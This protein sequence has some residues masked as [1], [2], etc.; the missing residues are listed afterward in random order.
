MRKWLASLAVLGVCSTSLTAQTIPVPPIGGLGQSQQVFFDDGTYEVGWK[1]SWPAA[2]TDGYAVDFDDIC[3]NMTVNGVS[4][5]TFTSS[6]TSGGPVGFGYIGLFP[7]NLGVSSLGY[8]PDLS[9]PLGM[10]SGTITGSPAPGTFTPTTVGYDLPDTLV[11]TTGGMHAVFNFLTGDSVSWLTAD[12]TGADEG[13]STF[14]FTGYTTPAILESWDYPIRAIGSVAAA[15]GSA[16][17]TVNNGTGNVPVGQTDI[18]NATLWSTC[19]TQP[20]IYLQG[21]FLPTFL[22]VPSFVLLTG[23]EN[24]SPVTNAFMGSLSAPLSDP[25]V[26]PC[27]P[28]GA[29]FGVGAFYLDNC[30]LKK[31]G[32]PKLR[33]S[34]TVTVTVTPNFAACNPCLCF[35]QLDDGS[36]DFFIWKVQNP[37]GSLDFFN[38]NHGPFNDLAGVDCGTGLTGMQIASWDFCGTGPSW[39][40]VGLYAANTGVDP[41]GG[42]PD[43]GTPVALS[44]SLSMAPGAADVG[45][46]ATPY[47]FASTVFASTNAVLLAGGDLN[48][49]AK[50][51]TGDTC[52]WHGSDSDGIDDD[53][54]TVGAGCTLI[55]SST[56]F[57]AVAGYSVPSI[58]FTGMN[59]MQKIDWF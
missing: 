46:P 48:T 2:P 43:L 29:V 39:A 38:V 12:A 53:S 59:W 23:Y 1:V 18:I 20:T 56:T 31:N 13:H 14:T 10:T 25:S 44:T 4:I 16:Y 41:S 7:D 17:I 11:P 5:A 28:A 32:K 42:T 8:T 15:P 21:V 58:P 26:G 24:F 49:A 9:L 52:V 45:Y 51:I 27:V 34:N 40:S 3:G 57:F 30:T 47:P 22:A 54:T 19:A 55:P 36:Q 6:T 37:A 35:G 50:W 33:L